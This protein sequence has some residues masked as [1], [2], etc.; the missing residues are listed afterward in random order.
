MDALHFTSCLRSQFLSQVMRARM[1][2]ACKQN[3]TASVVFTGAS[4][5]VGAQKASPG[6]GS[7]RHQLSTDAHVTPGTN[8][9]RKTHTWIELLVIVVSLFHKKS[10]RMS[11][12]WQ[13]FYLST[14][15]PTFLMLP[16]PNTKWK[17]V[18]E[19]IFGYCALLKVCFFV[20]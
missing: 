18:Y 1:E 5:L 6:P 4:K 12:S 10:F 19:G 9:L 8:E 13:S 11:C 2:R 20:S 16:L 3:D 14:D 7:R 17:R 15:V